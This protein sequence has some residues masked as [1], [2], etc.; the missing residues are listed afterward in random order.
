MQAYPGEERKG[1][2]GGQV[3]AMSQIKDL[4]DC[5]NYKEIN[6]CSLK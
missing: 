2:Q 4:H 6:E 3:E 5:S 1:F